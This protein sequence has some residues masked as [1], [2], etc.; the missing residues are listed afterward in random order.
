M[1]GRDGIGKTIEKGETYEVSSAADAD[2]NPP[3]VGVTGARYNWKDILEVAIPAAIVGG[4]AA[5][6]WPYVTESDTLPSN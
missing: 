4:T 3:P 5:I 6:V 2:Q 1:E